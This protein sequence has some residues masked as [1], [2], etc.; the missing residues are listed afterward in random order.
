[1]PFLL[2]RRALATALAAST[3]C[4][5]C[6]GF[7]L[8]SA[9]VRRRKVTAAS[10]VAPPPSVL[11]ND[12]D[13]DDLFGFGSG[14]EKHREVNG[15]LISDS[16]GIDSSNMAGNTLL[17][18]KPDELVELLGGTG[19]AKM[20]WSMLREGLDPSDPGPDGAAVDGEAS[21]ALSQSSRQPRSL[22][23]AARSAV[24]DGL[25]SLPPVVH[26][27]ASSDGTRK[28]LLRLRDGLEVECV[29]IPMTG[30]VQHRKSSGEEAEAEE[31]EEE[32]EEEALPPPLHI[33][34]PAPFPRLNPRS[35]AHNRKIEPE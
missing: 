12:E 1:M 23:K 8:P 24:R 9:G 30:S 7:S 22:G 5:H 17:S 35:Q 15:G 2:H 6:E 34:P 10:A 26:S 13:R 32:E 27:T 19:R 28:M 4:L 11:L 31:E 20:T 14:A 33:I 25:S 21:T 16:G 18:L 29:L 3:M